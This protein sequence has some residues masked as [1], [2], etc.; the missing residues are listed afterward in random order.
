[1][2]SLAKRQ[3]SKEDTVTSSRQL[4]KDSNE[5]ENTEPNAAEKK[6]ERVET[7]ISTQAAPQKPRFISTSYDTTLIWSQTQDFIRIKIMLV[8]VSDYYLKI[9]PCYA[10]FG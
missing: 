1:L 5:K 4:Q 10:D 9:T 2:K 8:G 6:E 7:T 3:T